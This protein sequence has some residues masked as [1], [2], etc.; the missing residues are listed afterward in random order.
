MLLGGDE[1]K[2]LF[3]RGTN[4]HFLKNNFII[5]FRDFSYSY[6]V[7]IHLQILAAGGGGY[8]SSCEV[9]GVEG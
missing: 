1:Q 4:K 3:V 8:Y 5:S 6:G 9:T 2:L 7:I